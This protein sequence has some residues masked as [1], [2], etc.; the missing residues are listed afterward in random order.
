MLGGP[1]SLRVQ[2]VAQSASGTNMMAA[3]TTAINAL[4]HLGSHARHR[5]FIQAHASSA[6]PRSHTEIGVILDR[7]TT[8]HE[9]RRTRRAGPR[10][11]NTLR[12]ALATRMGWLPASGGEETA[13]AA[14]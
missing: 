8:S 14:R 9:P 3:P 5:A 2:E 13:A 11:G 6:P 1:T 4:L 7:Y 10:P 12:S